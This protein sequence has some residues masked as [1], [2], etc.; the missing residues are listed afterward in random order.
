MCDTYNREIHNLVREESITIQYFRSNDKMSEYSDNVFS[1]T[2]LY[3]ITWEADWKCNR[4]IS[5]VNMTNDF[6]RVRSSRSNSLKKET[7]RREKKEMENKGFATRCERR[8]LPSWTWK[9]LRRQSTSLL[10]EG[11]G[12]HLEQFEK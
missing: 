12:W 10:G 11:V 9:M 3:C 1:T 8:R 4:C 7:K 5:R 6:H 2:V